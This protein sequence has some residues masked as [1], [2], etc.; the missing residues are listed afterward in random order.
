MVA[1]RLDDGEHFFIRDEAAAVMQLVLVDRAGQFLCLRR[2]I[3]MAVGKLTSFDAGSLTAARASF[4]EVIRGI[5]CRLGHVHSPI[6][7]VCIVRTEP[8]DTND[9]TQD[10]PG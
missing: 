2:E 3:I 5:F 9:F 8:Y 4:E 10:R 6:V 7:L 1:E